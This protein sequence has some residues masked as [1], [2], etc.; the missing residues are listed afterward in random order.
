MYSLSRRRA[1]WI[2]P[3]TRSRVGAKRLRSNPKAEAGSWAQSC[4]ALCL[5]A[6]RDGD[7]SR[8]SILQIVLQGELNPSWRSQTLW[9]ITNSLA[10]QERKNQH[11]HP[12]QWIDP[13]WVWSTVQCCR[14]MIWACNGS[15]TFFFLMWLHDSRVLMSLFYSV[16]VR[17]R[18]LEQF[19]G[20]CSLLHERGVSEG[21]LRREIHR[22]NT[23]SIR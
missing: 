4:A 10:F 6:E 7:P 1:C 17:R 9:N 20:V 14:S 3:S 21:V 23:Q 12:R 5:T 16:L 15:M 11:F 8:V 2:V 13:Q 22:W 18:Y 19:D